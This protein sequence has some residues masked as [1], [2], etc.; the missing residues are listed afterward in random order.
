MLD[1]LDREN[2]LCKGTLQIGERIVGPSCLRLPTLA[3]VYTADEIAPLAS[4]MPF[5]DAMPGPD[6]RVLEFA[7]EVG[8]PRESAISQRWPPKSPSC[9]S[10]SPRWPEP[11]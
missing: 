10:A 9:S 8:Y 6:I 2:R 7:G 11:P 1:W 5:L 3:V 4:V